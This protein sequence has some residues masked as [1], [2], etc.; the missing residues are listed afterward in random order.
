ME[1]RA[2]K[3]AAKFCSGLLILGFLASFGTLH[4]LEVDVFVSSFEL[5]TGQT[6]KI[7]FSVLDQEPSGL[8]MSWGL[9]PDSFVEIGARKE[10]RGRDTVFLKEWVSREE[11]SF[12]L[13]PFVVSG[14]SE[15]LELPPIY[16][17]SIPDET[18]SPARMRWRSLDA[19]FSVG[20][21]SV[22][23]LEAIH[24]GVLRSV[25]CPAPENAIISRLDEADFSGIGEEP[26]RIVGV[27]SWTPL[28]P[29]SQNAPLA[30]ASWETSDGKSVSLISDSAIFT[31]ARPAP[32]K[33]DERVSTEIL[34]GFASVPTR[35]E[36]IIDRGNPEDI[37][38][39]IELRRAEHESLFPAPIRKERLALEKKLS[40]RDSLP[41]PP[42]AW[43]GPAVFCSALLVFLS[44][45]LRLIAVRRRI[46]IHFFHAGILVAAGLAF[47]AG[48]L[49]TADRRESA[50][51]LSSR[52]LQV[53]EQSS[54]LIDSIPPGTAV[55]VIASSGTWA[56]VETAGKIRGWITL[57]ELAFYTRM[58]R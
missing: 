40:L 56:Q 41:V 38:R 57:S 9:I 39:L 2:G 54:S 36:Q 24:A 50:V 20:K 49:Y 37:D 43:K 53:P 5:S 42:A 13:G 10:R 31:A 7:E 45:C 23:V 29:G 21:P 14:E 19:S 52:L 28:H 16:I 22:L 6:L 48:Y 4:S 55:R 30:V 1:A 25:D 33:K 18:D 15:D 58:E 47:F 51:A 12:S 46:F 32:D 44:F 27:W 34:K 17:V 11:G 35:E 26:W 8:E 3:S